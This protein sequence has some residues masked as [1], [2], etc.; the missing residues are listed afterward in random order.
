MKSKKSNGPDKKQKSNTDLSTENENPST[1]ETDKSI[2]DTASSLGFGD[3]EPQIR[4][5]A[6]QAAE[7]IKNPPKLAS[8]LIGFVG[9]LLIGIT[10]MSKRR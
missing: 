4:G 10:I 2:L 1:L 6:L 8:F 9:T 3:L 7:I 5:E